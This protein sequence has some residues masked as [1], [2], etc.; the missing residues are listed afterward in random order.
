MDVQIR[1]KNN[2]NTIHFDEEAPTLQML[3]L[4]I[5]KQMGVKTKNQ[6]IICRGK[7]LKDPEEV[8]QK[9]MR[10]LLTEETGPLVVQNKSATP[11][12]AYSSF[13]PQIID[14]L[15]EQ[16]HQNIIQMGPPEGFTKPI[17]F[18][19]SVLPQTPIYVRNG[20][21]TKL[22]QGSRC[23]LSFESDALCLI[24]DDLQVERIFTSDIT[25]G[26]A[27]PIPN[28]EGFLALGIITRQG[29]KWIFFIPQQFQ[30]ILKTLIPS[31][32]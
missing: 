15:K 10:L 11:S 3:M 20:Q 18:Q 31:L 24:T 21:G 2:R 16:Y 13:K 5:E 14:T 30:Q 25:N 7:P 17:Q 19:A 12:R 4:E 26:T 22:P 8:L 23:V 28:Y 9:G 29:N 6:K 27:L 32:N 1:F